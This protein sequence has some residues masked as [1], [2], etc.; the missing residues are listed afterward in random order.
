MTLNPDLKNNLD[1]LISTN[2]VVLFMK[3]SPQA[4]QCRFS[5]RI[6]ETL[7]VLLDQYHTVNVLESNE[8][9]EGIKIY[10]D[11]PTIPQLYVNGEFIGGCDIIQEM[12][13]SGLLSESLGIDTPQPTEPRITVSDSAAENL[14]EACESQEGAAIRVLVT[15]DGRCSMALGSI[16]PKDLQTTSNGVTLVLDP[17]TANRADGLFIDHS[18]KGFSSGYEMEIR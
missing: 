14:I 11:W 6:V 1:T 9:R 18:R 3:G 5:A 2:S 10:S 16:G 8:L 13:D 4:P 17:F 7:D 15:K 12:N